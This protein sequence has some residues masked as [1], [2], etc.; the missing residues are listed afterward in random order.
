MLD[1]PRDGHSAGDE[2][3]ESDGKIER[4]A[5]AIEKHDRGETLTPVEERIVAYTVY[6]A[7]CSACGMQR[8]R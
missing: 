5:R 1:Q 2:A 8:R 7:G 4:I 3:M 6:A